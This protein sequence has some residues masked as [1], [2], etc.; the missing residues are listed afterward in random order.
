LVGGESA[1]AWEGFCAGE[2]AASRRGAGAGAVGRLLLL[3]LLA[4]LNDCCPCCEQELK[5]LRAAVCGGAGCRA[6][7][8]G[9]WAGVAQRGGVDLGAAWPVLWVSLLQ[10]VLALLWRCCIASLLAADR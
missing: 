8:A 10:G 7:G 9:E 3:L 6:C 2:S 5:Y 4:C 1:G